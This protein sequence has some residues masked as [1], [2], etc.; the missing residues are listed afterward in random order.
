MI[1]V[2]FATTYHNIFCNEYIT[3]LPWGRIKEDMEFF[4]TITTGGYNGTGSSGGKNSVIMGK[5]TFRSLKCV[6]LT[7]RIN[8]VVSTTIIHTELD[9]DDFLIARTLE[10]ALQLMKVYSPDGDSFII[11]GRRLIQEA[12]DK[13]I[14][15]N[16]YHTVIDGEG[17]K[18]ITGIPH[19]FNI[20][21]HV[22]SMKPVETPE[23]TL[24]FKHLTRNIVTEET[25][26][27][28]LVKRVLSKG[29]PR[30]DRTEVGTISVF[31]EHLRLN[32]EH[33]FPLLTSK[34]VYWK[35][36]LEELLFFISGKTDTK[37]LEEK[38]VN[39]W[40]G[41]TSRESL[42]KSG[43][44]R[45]KEGEYGAVYGYNWRHFGKPYTPLLERDE[46]YQESGGFDQLY[47][48][49]ESIKR[50]PTSRRHYVTSWNPT[51]LGEVPLP[52]CH[53]S[54]QFYVDSKDR[55]SCQVYMRS[56][57]LF[58]GL[59]FNIA[60]Y[61]TLTYMI[62]KL[63]GKTPYELIFSIGDAHIYSNH[64]EQC[65]TLISRTQRPLPQLVI[66]GEQQTIDDFKAED[67]VIKDYNPHPIIK[68][69]MAV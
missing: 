41:N 44:T 50:T 5:D 24:W 38:G 15:D 3:D 19:H 62:A 31:G 18:K 23:Y 13:D 51:T 46:R 8:I 61:A 40:K 6:P 63:T 60:S 69:E 7:N 43:L 33:S 57:D 21:M 35:G 68:G 66:T 4:K 58:L 9:K 55:L 52:S 45:F 47:F 14:V 64:I 48:L 37:L 54:Y 49:V 27:I 16:V 32:I 65:K 1:N 10:E 30:D 26:Y 42:D 59:P 29:E 22:E 36:V 67:F 20:P 2:I 28:E 11:G 56:C 25:G 34:R 12:L 53:V 17:A 39:I